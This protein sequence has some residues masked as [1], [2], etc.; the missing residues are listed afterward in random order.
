M[1]LFVVVVVVV[2]DC[3]DND[4]GVRAQPDHDDD[5]G[6]WPACCYII[7]ALHTRERVCIHRA[8]NNN[9]YYLFVYNI[10]EKKMFYFVP[11]HQ[12]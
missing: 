2:V 12:R 8:N 3:S 4:D 5:P 1:W 7:H 10:K 9:Y 11:P 6:L